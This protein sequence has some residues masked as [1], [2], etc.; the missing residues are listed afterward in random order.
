MLSGLVMGKFNES[1][2]SRC[3]VFV[4]KPVKAAEDAIDTERH[5]IGPGPL[6]HQHSN[7]DPYVG[8]SGYYNCTVF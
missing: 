1:R 6:C 7:Y 2:Y 8:L 3:P 5:A 4:T